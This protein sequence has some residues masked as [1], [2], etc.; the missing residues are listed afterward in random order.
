MELRHLR[1]FVMVADEEN[2][3]RAAT[4]LHVSQPAL[5][6]QIRDLEEELSLSLFERGARSLH[7]TEAGHVFLTEARAVLQRLDQAVSAVR[8]VA[9]TSGGEIHVGFAPSLTVE[10]LP[11]AL[12][13]FQEEFPGIHVRLHDLSTQE[14]LDGLCEGTLDV[15]LMV[16]PG[17]RAR[18]K[19]VFRE[20]RRLAVC[21]AAHPSHPLARSKKVALGDLS[22]ERLISYDSKEYPEYQAWLKELFSK[23]G[24]L[25]PISEEHESSTGLIAAVEAGRGVALV[26]EGFDCF[27]GPR[28]S[29]R[30]LTPKPPPFVVGV[31]HCRDLRSEPALAFV[32]SVKG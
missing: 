26:Q 25:P 31:A 20:V 11:D 12:R 5:S 9:D 14:M 23:T 32:D 29:V 10:I 3:T 30:V 1:Y 2:V 8:A 13:R 4:R 15:A 7:L 24:S 18:S 27:S 6:R 28:L 17:G 16:R 21:V 22:K 19:I